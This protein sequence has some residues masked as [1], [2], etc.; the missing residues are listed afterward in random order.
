MAT[1]GECS[2]WMTGRPGPCG[3]HRHRA[4]DVHRPR[5]ASWATFLT[6]SF[7][8]D[9]ARQ[10]THACNYLLTVD[11]EMEPVPG[12]RFANWGAA[13][14]TFLVPDLSTL[15]VASWLDRSALV[16]CDVMDEGTTR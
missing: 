7:V 12:Y 15:R 1:Q 8:A 3:C 16:L 5:G 11:M 6:P 9:A 13:T 14:A 4:G 2:R 10:G